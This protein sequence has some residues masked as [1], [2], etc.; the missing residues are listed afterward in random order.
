MS[1]KGFGKLAFGAAIGAGLGLLFAPKK[2]EETRKELK[3]KLDELLKQAKEI[4]AD[5]VKELSMQYKGNGKDLGGCGVMNAVGGL[6][7]PDGKLALKRGEVLD[8]AIT[9]VSLHGKLDK[10]KPFDAECRFLVESINGNT[11]ELDYVYA[12][13]VKLGDEERLI[14]TGNSKDG[15]KMGQ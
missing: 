8:L 2:G 10:D 13:T 7:N 9:E 12:G 15:Y 14:L 1:K 11:Q 4:D 5:D 3:A 6:K